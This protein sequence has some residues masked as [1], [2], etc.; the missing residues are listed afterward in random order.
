MYNDA[1]RYM[2][3]YRAGNPF[4]MLVHEGKGRQDITPLTE[5]EV[6]RLGDIS[7]EVHGVLFGSTFRAMILFA[8]WT[9][10]RP[11]E[12]A[13]MRHDD[14]DFAAGTV[15]VERQL[16]K[17]GLKLPKTK[18]KRLIVMPTQ[19]ADAIR[20]MPVQHVEWLFTTPTGKSFSKGSW[21]YYWRPVRDAFERELPKTHWLPKRL[22]E[23]PQDH[24]DFYELRHYCG[25]LLADR[26]MT[27]R[28]I[29]EQLGNSEEVCQRVY[30]HLYKDR[31]R[32][33][34]RAAFE[35]PEVV[36][37]VELDVLGEAGR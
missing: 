26:G 33:R 10:C 34:I 15:N 2:E 7:V 12:L 11:G 6:R 19:A 17:D 37:Q 24:L 25:S 23:D 36:E 27:A 18:R 30:I 32:D 31:S 28:D 21:G 9:G 35:Q 22:E 5:V 20:S 29:A 3:G 14:L 13:G 16:R 8:A 4:A 1:I